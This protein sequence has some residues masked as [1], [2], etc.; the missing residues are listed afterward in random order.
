M[1]S[2]YRPIVSIAMAR[3]RRRRKDEEHSILILHPTELVDERRG[4]V[5][6]F[7]RRFYIRQARLH[8]LINATSE[9]IFDNFFSYSIL[10]Y[11]ILYY[12]FCYRTSEEKP[13]RTSAT[14]GESAPN[15]ALNLIKHA[16]DCPSKAK[17]SSLLNLFIL[18]RGQRRAQM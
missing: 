11:I 5:F 9:Q 2:S 4:M 8:I 12:F 1:I 3:I 10:F 15:A 17:Y 7:L 6:K 16:R 14:G 18:R 13:G